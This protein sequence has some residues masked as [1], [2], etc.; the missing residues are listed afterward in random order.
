M[1]S[2]KPRKLV[3]KSKITSMARKALIADRMHGGG[4]GDPTKKEPASM[5]AV[6]GPGS[7]LYA[8]D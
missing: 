6:R 5:D 8:S 7:K 3:K 2:K 1:K 4:K